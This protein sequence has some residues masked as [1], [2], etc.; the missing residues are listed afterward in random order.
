MLLNLAISLTHIPLKSGVYLLKDK[1]SKIIYVGK[2]KCLRERVRNY[3]T[4]PYSSKT[5]A[6]NSKIDSIDYIV[7][8]SE[9]DALVLEAN[10]IKLH[11][12]HYN[13]RL[14]DD[15]K[16][17]YIKI[18]IQDKFAR[19][20]P[21]RDLRDR[22]AIYFGPYTDVKSMKHALKSATEIFPIR[23]CKSKDRS[24]K[25]EN[26]KQKSEDKK[27]KSSKVCLAYHIGKCPGPCEGKISVPAYKETIQEL[28]DFLSG[29]SNKVEEKL[30]SKMQELSKRLDFEEAA[31]IRDKLTSIQSIILKQQVVFSKPIDLD[32]FGLARRRSQSCVAITIVREG[33]ILGQ[34]HYI[35]HIQSKSTD[36]EIIRAFILQYY[37]TAFYIPQE[38]VLPEIDEQKEIEKWLNRP[39]SIPQEREKLE[40][41]KFATRNAEVWLKS[42]Q[43]ERVNKALDELKNY[44]K[45]PTLPRRIEA[46]DISN[47][48]GKYAVGS[49]VLF[50]N[51]KAQKSGYR[52]FRIKT[53]V[54]INDVA[55]MKE[56]ITRKTRTYAQKPQTDNRKPITVKLPHLVLVDGGI[57]QVRAARKCLPAE[58]PVFGLAKRFEQLYT[59][60]NKVI[61]LPKSS[62]ALRLLQRIRDEAHRFAFFYHK[63]IR[64]HSLF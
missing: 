35:L 8:D 48:G 18:T 45:L 37:K 19:V 63:K 28:I 51:G 31:K 57:G 64:D 26:R 59:P 62:S 50:V 6:L 12:P 22:S 15:K 23:V 2:A 16:Y 25:T 46:Y 32:V 13:I 38:I 58:I 30:K 52:K 7:T 60:E 1:S 40:L 24:Q 33:R 11:L 56:I 61:S 53:V 36:G 43:V 10:L 4:P 42:Q 21:T 27:S 55:M 9:I 41:I 17:P 47:I 3:F 5:R 34:E 49:C 44:L 54:G 39:I 14:K 29:K 20:F